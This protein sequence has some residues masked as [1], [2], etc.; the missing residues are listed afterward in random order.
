VY[1]RMLTKFGI[2][3]NVVLA[4]FGSALASGPCDQDISDYW[5]EKA[6]EACRVVGVSL[7][8]P[9]FTSCTG[10]ARAVSKRASDWALFEDAG[11]QNSVRTALS[12]YNDTCRFMI[13]HHE[14]VYHAVTYAQRHNLHAQ[15]NLY[16]CRLALTAVNWGYYEKLNNAGLLAKFTIRPPGGDKKSVRCPFSHPNFRRSTGMC[17][18][19]Q[20]NSTTV[21]PV[22]SGGIVASVYD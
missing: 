20:H 9:S 13:G 4:S 16:Q 15:C 8:R 10:V 12:A 21:P 3:L 7:E 2:V 22:T 1:S 6:E 17:F 5:Y 11:A 19:H 18:S 14:S